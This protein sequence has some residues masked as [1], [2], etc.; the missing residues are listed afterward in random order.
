[1][2]EYRTLN[3]L[4]RPLPEWSTRHDPCPWGDAHL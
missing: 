4:L 2:V 1:M 3:E